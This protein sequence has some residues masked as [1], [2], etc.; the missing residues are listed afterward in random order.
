MRVTIDS[1]DENLEAKLPAAAARV[2]EE[3]KPLNRSI[4]DVPADATQLNWFI[5]LS[6]ARIECSP[7]NTG[8]TTI[9]SRRQ[10]NEQ[11]AP[12]TKD[13]QKDSARTGWLQGCVVRCG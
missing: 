9:N 3:R 2:N 1:S 12:Q 5:A 8:Q 10:L 13:R 4:L 6:R 11:T 7:A